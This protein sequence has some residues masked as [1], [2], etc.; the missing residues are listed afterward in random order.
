MI[1]PEQE[2][3]W[4]S[5]AALAL[6]KFLE[7]PHG[8]GFLARLAWLGPSL[9]SRTDATTRLIES[10]IVEGFELAISTMLSLVAPRPRERHPTEIL[11][12]LDGP[13]EHWKDIDEQIEK[14]Q[15]GED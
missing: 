12:D 7:S 9:T 4:E 11:P 2:P 3:E 6:R 15:K 5:E 1:R 10:G 8:P 13:K 14:A